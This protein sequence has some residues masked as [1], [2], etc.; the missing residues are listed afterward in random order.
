MNPHFSIHAPEHP[1]PRGLYAQVDFIEP[2]GEGLTLVGLDGVDAEWF[3]EFS[4]DH[5]LS[6]KAASVGDCKAFAQ[7]APLFHLQLTMFSD[8]ANRWFSPKTRRWLLL[9]LSDEGQ[10]LGQ[11]YPTLFSPPQNVAFDAVR[12]PPMHRRSQQLNRLML[13]PSKA[14]MPRSRPKPAALDIE[15]LAVLDVG[16]GSA[17]AL[18]CRE[19]VARI[20]F[21]V[22]CGVY[23]NAPTR[24]PNISFC[25]CED[26]VVVLSH[27]DAD[28]WAGATIDTGLLTRTWIAPIPATIKH[29]VFLMNIWTAGGK[30]HL[31]STSATVQ[32]GSGIKLVRCKGPAS[33]RNE[34][35]LAL[36]AEREGKRWLLPGDA[37][38][39]NIPGALNHRFTGLV[40]TH[41]GARVHGPGAAAPSPAPQPDYARLAYSFGPGNAHGKYGVSHPRPAG[42][43]AYDAVGWIHSGWGVLP[44]GSAVAVAPGHARATAHHPTAHLNGIRIG[45]TVP[46]GVLPHLAACPKAMPLTQT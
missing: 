41:H 39:H 14:W 17:N 2:L 34:S 29:I 22:G 23:S 31:L 12:L 9:E 5:G 1:L 18:L 33:D 6:K 30:T 3:A 44:P 37:S 32:L 4:E 45:W 26:P 27:W 40:A 25:Q 21:D 15:E 43:H 46:V 16:Q 42:V 24:P 38:Y 13:V 20:Y 7:G 28:H 11:L 10:L 36:I 8:E 19:G 35:G